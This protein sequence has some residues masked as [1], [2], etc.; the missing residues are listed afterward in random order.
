MRDLEIILIFI[1]V[2]CLSVVQALPAK[3]CQSHLFT[4]NLYRV[5]E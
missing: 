4:L 1:G 2:N 5:H 3:M